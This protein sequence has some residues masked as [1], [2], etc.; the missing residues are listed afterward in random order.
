[1]QE[2]ALIERVARAGYRQN[3]QKKRLP[4]SEQGWALTR[5]DWLDVTAAM[6]ADLDTAGYVIVPRE[7]TEAMLDAPWR[8]FPSV[9]LYEP[10]DLTQTLDSIS[11]ERV[12]R[13][14]RDAALAERER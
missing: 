7:P 2:P 13:A 6:F 8:A 14:M 11:F 1:M 12:W 9:Q 3:Q 10:T 5:S 4:E